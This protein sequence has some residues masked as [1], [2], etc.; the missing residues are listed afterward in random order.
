[1][2]EKLGLAA[3]AVGAVLVFTP[4]K[5]SARVAFGVAVG[6]AYAY[7]A[8]PYDYGCPVYPDPYTGVC[9]AYAY[10]APYAYAVPYVAPYA[11]F[12]YYGGH[13]DRDDFNG[14]SYYG[15]EGQDFRG[16]QG[17]FSHAFS[18]GAH[19]FGGG[20]RNFGGGHRR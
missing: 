16:G 1:M 9:P 6:P 8:A 5:A 14:R 10:P 11:T 18:G 12:G 15:H 4:A 2:L 7:P 17:G 13:H 20:G 19:Q 3:L